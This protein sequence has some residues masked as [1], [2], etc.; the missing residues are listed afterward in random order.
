MRWHK[1]LQWYPPPEL[2][3]FF[4]GLEPNI[5]FESWQCDGNL[6]LMIGIAEFFMVPRMQTLGKAFVGI[7]QKRKRFS[8]R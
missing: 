8:K 5:K 2:C 3:N 6:G 7:Y 1:V 4:Q